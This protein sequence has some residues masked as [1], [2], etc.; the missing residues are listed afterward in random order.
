MTDVPRLRTLR[1][2]SSIHTWTSLISMVFLLML[3]L[4]GLPLIFHHELDHLLGY[5][6]ALPEMPAGMP[7]VPL[8]RIVAAAAAKQPGQAVQFVSFDKDEPDAVLIG[9]G[10][11]LQTVPADSYVGLDRRTA[12]VLME[13]APGAGPI[14]F[15]L[16]LHTDLF[17]DL[18]GK[19]FLGVMALLFVAAIVSGVVLY[20]PFMKKLDFGT[21]RRGRSARI[22]WLDWHNL[23]G[24]ATIVWA[25][26]VG[27]TGAVNT[28]ADLMLK[29]WQMGQLAEMTAPY[30]DAPRP[31]TL[32]SLDRA[33]ATAEA[34]APDMRT[35]FIA[36]PGTPFSSNNHYAV[37]MAGDTPLTARLL[38][39]AL[40]DAQT[41]DLTDMRAMP[42]YV[43]ALFLSQPLHFG[44]YGGLPLKVVWALFDLATIIVLGSGLYLW[45]ARRR[46]RASRAAVL[47]RRAN[48]HEG[49]GR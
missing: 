37:F 36:F 40:I 22:K 26:V 48:A 23:L 33:V 46:P 7:H 19:L 38:K 15:L 32:V 1:I 3:C 4:T 25:L 41:G 30:R 16:K 43:R 14:G 24:A 2:W 11:T 39:P 47:P 10:K 17:L 45:I 12:A 21:V 35:Q 31:E 13:T 6:P 18:P 28:W 20:A 8:D 34:A 49:T 29:L 9:L 42:W 44:D 27:T 5:A